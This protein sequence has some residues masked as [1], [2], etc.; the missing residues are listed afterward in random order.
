MTVYK[1]RIYPDKMQ[2]V[3]SAKTFDCVRKVWNLH[4]YVLILIKRR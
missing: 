1:Y 2:Q 3:S 4:D